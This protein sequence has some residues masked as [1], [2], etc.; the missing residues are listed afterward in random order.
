MALPV[1]RSL[2]VLKVGRSGGLMAQGKKNMDKSPQRRGRLKAKA[3]E[4][5]M[6]GSSAH[7]PKLCWL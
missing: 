6:R 4:S 7:V 3:K 2:W 5:E 1:S